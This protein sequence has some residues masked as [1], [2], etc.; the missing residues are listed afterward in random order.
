MR[1]HL[2]R[3]LREFRPGHEGALPALLV[4]DLRGPRRA[5]PGRR[6][7][8][9]VD[10]PL[11]GASIGVRHRSFRQPHRADGAAAVRRTPVDAARL[12][13]DLLE[14]RDAVL[15]GPR[16]RRGTWLGDRW[17]E[18]GL[19]DPVGASPQFTGADFTDDAARL[20]P[21]PPRTSSRNEVLPHLDAIEA[22]GRGLDAAAAQARRR[23]RPLMIDIPEQDG[24]LG[25]DKATSM[26]VSERAAQCASFSVS[27]GAHTGIGTLPLVY[28]G[29][30]AQKAALPPEARERRDGSRRT[31]SPSPAPGSDAT[32]A[33]T[34][35]VARP[36]ART[37]C[38]NGVKQFITN[39]GFADLFTV[40]A[41]IDGEK[42]TAFLVERDVR[43]RLAPDRRSRSSASRARRP[44]S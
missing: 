19:I 21:R 28:Y 42:F 37:T 20:T 31:R 22:Q 16:R 35:A 32:A 25:L 30:A 26:L 15:A 29:T 27:W 5:A 7:V 6:R 41:K 38:L 13:S 4:K 17:S 39:A 43:R 11:A 36:T 2:A 34:T 18:A 12:I 10:E 33:R 24:G 44:A 3:R 9:V 40:F 1:I 14:S 8:P 23:A